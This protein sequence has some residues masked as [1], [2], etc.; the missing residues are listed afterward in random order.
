MSD[1]LPK[2]GAP[3]AEVVIDVDDGHA[4]I[5]GLAFECH[6]P[7]R[8]RFGLFDEG[9]R[10]FECQIVDDVDEEEGRAVARNGHGP[11]LERP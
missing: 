8:H 7:A 10:P 2:V 6:K 9:P 5:S 4:G 3:L 1:G 11:H